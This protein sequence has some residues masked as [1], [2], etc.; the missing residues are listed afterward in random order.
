M[1]SPCLLLL[2]L[3]GFVT[4][5]SAQQR[6][7]FSWKISD[8]QVSTGMEN[9]MTA[10][11]I[12]PNE[13]TRFAPGS[14]IISPGGVD[15]YG[16][17]FP[18]DWSSSL[19]N[20]HLGLNPFNKSTGE[21]R[22]NRTLRLGL[23][24]QQFSNTLY[25]TSNRSSDRIDTLLNAN[26]SSIFGFVDSVRYENTYADYSA[27][28]LK[29]DAAFLWSTDASRRVSLF[30]GVGVNAGLLV[31]A[32]T[33]IHS[34]EWT[35]RQITDSTGYPISFTNFNGDRFDSREERFN[36]KTGW[37]GTAYIPFG[38]DFRIGKKHSFWKQLHLFTEVR[39]ALSFVSIP[40]TKTV[41]IPGVQNTFGLKV[42]W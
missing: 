28:A 12:R 13:F 19:L 3:A 29:L 41:L 8:F 11:S 21:T 18:Y 22:L 20:I 6:N 17:G 7:T 23:S 14:S 2:L 39:P 38:V 36:N 9:S 25:S 27:T 15:P 24:A 33:Y 31:A 37:A 34:H 16:F 40:E 30:A 4:K 1:R 42:R 26:S 10:F 35:E 5:V 32:Q